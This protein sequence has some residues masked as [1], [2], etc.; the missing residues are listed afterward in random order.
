M[1]P[2]DFLDVFGGHEISAVVPG[3]GA[4]FFPAGAPEVG[5]SDI[6]I[7]GDG[8]GGRVADDVAEVASEPCPGLEV[9]AVVV[10]L[11]ARE[12]QQIG[13][14]RLEILDDVILRQVASVLGAD[15]IARKSSHHDN[16]LIN[17]ILADDT[18]V[19][20]GFTVRDA[21]FDV[22]A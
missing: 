12:E 21:V 8:D 2:L 11:I 4:G 10:D 1:C 6:V 18:G 22:P 16:V 3:S 5:L 9:A 20:R 13:L 17:R 14:E 7:V 19:E 15:G